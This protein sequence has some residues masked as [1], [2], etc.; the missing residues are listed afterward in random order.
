[1]TRAIS[2]EDYI[3]Q[4]GALYSLMGEFAVEFEIICLNM[5]MG[6]TMLAQRSGLQDQNIMQAAMAEYTAYPL[7]KVFRSMFMDSNWI[8]HEVE[9]ALK[10]IN[11][12]MSRLIET[13]NDYIHGTVFVGYGNGSETEFLT[14]SGHK[15]KNTASGT[16]TTQ[17]SVD[18]ETFRP[19]LNE[20]RE[21]AALV[22]ATW[23]RALYGELS[24][25]DADAQVSTGF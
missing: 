13:R 17:L 9:G 20:C 16:S 5:R 8:T 2:D 11:K 19:I 4:T 15:I 6:I 18:E 10:D 1:M 3:Q 24:V 22:R 25:P 14:A 23:V 12:R 21:L 7:L